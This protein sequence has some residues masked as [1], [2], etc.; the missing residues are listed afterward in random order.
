MPHDWNAA[1]RSATARLRDAGVDSPRVDAELLAAY[2]A[3]VSRSGLWTAGSP[4]ADELAR[5]AE[6]VARRVARQPLQH[7][8]GTAAFWRGELAVG[9][10]V[11]VPRPETEL[12]VEWALR[13]LA[14]VRSP[15]VV[16]LCAGSGAI[17]HAVATERRD[18]TVYV[19]EQQPEAL[20]W[21]RRNMTGTSATIVEGDAT[22]PST[23]AN[24]D[25]VCD[26]V[27]SNPPYVPRGAAESVSPEVAADPATALYA[28]SDGLDVIRPLIPRAA[29]LLRPGGVVGIE[30]DDSHGDTVGDLLRRAGFTDVAAHRD[31]AGRPRFATG[32]KPSGS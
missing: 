15:V 2:T 27:L 19:V 32:R 12:L 8:V 4:G 14:Q 22:S 1:V 13:R 9:P 16:D 20:V 11:F 10:G 23:L 5:F 18:A 26:A 3:G 25:G 17:G 29:T 7:I 30:H 28:G 31:L 21:L 6:L 24:R